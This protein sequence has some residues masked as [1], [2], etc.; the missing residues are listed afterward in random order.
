MDGIKVERANSAVILKNTIRSSGVYG[1]TLR[2][3]DNTEVRENELSHNSAGGSRS[4]KG[5]APPSATPSKGIPSPTT[6]AREP[7]GSCCLAM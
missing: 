4:P 1:I 5:S 6:R 2:G 3:S 7:K